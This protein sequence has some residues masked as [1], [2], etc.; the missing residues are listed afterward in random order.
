VI[1]VLWGLLL[2][3]FV[4]FLLVMVVGMVLFMIVGE[5]GG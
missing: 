5:L 2:A 3:L 1:E 4:L